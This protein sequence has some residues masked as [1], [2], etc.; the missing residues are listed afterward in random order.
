ML[1]NIVHKFNDM[2]LLVY[3]WRKILLNYMKNISDFLKS[4]F[5]MIFI[6]LM[7]ATGTLYSQQNKID[8]RDYRKLHYL[9]EEEMLAPVKRDPNFTE[10][11]PPVGPVRMVAEFEP[12]Q[13]VL[14]RYPFG[15]PYTVIAEMAEELPVI[16]IVSS[17]SQGS[18]VLS[19]YEQN[20]VNTAN[21]SFL[22]APTDS[23]WTRDYGPWFVFDGNNQ[24]GICDFPYDRPRPTDDNIPVKVAQSLGINLFGMNLTH[25][26]GNMMADGF[27]FAAS[28]DLVFE[29]NTDLTEQQIRDK[30]EAYLGINQYH[31]TMDPLDDYI[32]HIDCWGKYLAP[33]KILIGSV[34]QSDYRY[35]DY[36]A[37]A[38][39][40]ASQNSAYGY[41]YKVYRVFSPGTAPN[42]PYTNSIILNNKVLVPLTGSQWD[43]EAIAVYEEAMPGY[44]IIGMTWD[45]WYNTDALHCR[46][47]G[48][49]D[50]DMLF[51]D[52]RP[53][54]GTVDWQ[55]S[56][57]VSVKIIP[58]SGE[59]LISDSLLVNYQ[60][61]NGAYQT[62]LLHYSESSNYVGY[63]KNYSESDTVR[64]FVSAVDVAGNRA[65]LPYMGTA[66]PN[67][68]V[69]EEQL[70]A[71]LTITPDTLVFIDEYVGYFRILN[72]T[73]SSVSIESISV[74]NLVW[75]PTLPNF[76]YA[77]L[78]GDSLI[79]E[80]DVDII[81]LNP[82]FVWLYSTIF[83]TS[84]IST[85]Q[86]SVKV[87]S[88]LLETIGSNTEKE[89]ISVHPNPFSNEIV[90]DLP[91]L[92]SSEV[93]LKIYDVFGKLV[94]SRQEKS[95]DK[96]IWN[97]KSDQGN[98]VNNGFYYY[99]LY[100]DNEMF[101]GKMI[102]LN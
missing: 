91:S 28:T 95:S 57:A 64:Y 8:N 60:V 23:Y 101:T 36:E 67:I 4:T 27:G 40:F 35:D 74:D 7:C 90:F 73:S 99:Q 54:Y 41:P 13:A 63:I 9:S 6:M 58:Y 11:D 30:M 94:Y 100:I 84:D 3:L 52:H 44:E 92:K 32:K 61:N 14:I 20:G 38:D 66:D 97:G 85:Q 102:R 39:Y 96:L 65:R 56:L 87:N 98:V 70:I 78:A 42:T 22:I 53:L 55:D 33:D 5:L 93:F 37:V 17:N 72:A 82:A 62:A 76:P 77:L 16:T 75:L 81:T 59:A 1:A 48:I 18:Q 29:E 80:V 71:D 88:D 26:G 50:L 89:I 49:A 10:T 83:V 69:V 25:T 86:V 51:L 21:C 31:V 34:P 68:F 43:D 2:A 45:S 19:M 46:A 12:M 24:P 79:V 47:I 15:I